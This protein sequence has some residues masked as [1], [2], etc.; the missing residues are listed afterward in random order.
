MNRNR[1]E[2]QQ[3]R[4]CDSENQADESMT[5]RQT[6]LATRV[7]MVGCVHHAHDA[8]IF[9]N[10]CILTQYFFVSSSSCTDTLLRQLTFDRQNSELGSIHLWLLTGDSRPFRL[11]LTCHLLFCRRQEIRAFSALVGVH[12][13]VWFNAFDSYR[14]RR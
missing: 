3:T 5:F 12:F 4:R 10:I 8:L 1:P 7:A 13:L 9:A 14:A 2:S 6:G 11:R